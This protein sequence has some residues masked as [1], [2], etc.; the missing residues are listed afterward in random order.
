MSDQ[1]RHGGPCCAHTRVSYRTRQIEG[2]LTTGWWECDSGCGMCFTT[3]PHA[4]AIRA[5]LALSAVPAV[6]AEP[7]MAN[8]VYQHLRQAVSDMG[9]DEIPYGSLDGALA[10]FDWAW[11]ELAAGMPVATSPAVPA[12]PLLQEISES[13]VK[14]EAKHAPMQSAHEG[15][16]V[17]LEELDE[18]W[19]EVKRQERDPAA[20]RKEAK[21]VAAMG[22]RFLKDV[23]DAGVPGSG[24]RPAPSVEYDE[25]GRPCVYLAEVGY[26]NGGSNRCLFTTRAEAVFFAKDCLRRA[27]GM[28]WSAWQAPKGKYPYE[29]DR[30]D[31]RLDPTFIASVPGGHATVTRMAAAMRWQPAEEASARAACGATM[32]APPVLAEMTSTGA[33]RQKVRYAPLSYYSCGH[34]MDQEAIPAVCPSCGIGRLISPPA[35]LTGAETPPACQHEWVMHMI[36]MPLQGYSKPGRTTCKFCGIDKPV[37]QHVS[38]LG[39]PRCAA[40]SAALAAL[41]QDMRK[42]A[43]QLELRA[44]S[45]RSEG[46]AMLA[47][48]L[49]AQAEVILGFATKLATVRAGER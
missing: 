37:Q 20:M 43:A 49:Q 8:N 27:T 6:P 16:S 36:E 48:R 46:R 3:V 38:S 18:L 32:P 9:G 42:E 28:D 26:E 19:E 10:G 25:W 22:L 21:H 35:P 14:A 23:C 40:Q 1:T 17:I 39:C 2:G 47:G 4:E 33:E 7:L 30:D 12:E 45:R 24:E 34:A 31:V 13:L 11:H 44:H 5:E 29:T 41:E 15:Y